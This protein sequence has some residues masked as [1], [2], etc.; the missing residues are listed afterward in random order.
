MYHPGDLVKVIKNLTETSKFVLG[1]DEIYTK[2]Q[3]G[4]GEEAIIIEESNS[5]YELLFSDGDQCAWYQHDWL[6]L[7]DNCRWDLYDK[8]RKNG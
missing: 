7:I 1:S 3:R 5:Q 6:E 4:F 2:Y 8:W